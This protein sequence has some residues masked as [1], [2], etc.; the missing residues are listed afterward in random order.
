MW[1]CRDRL[2]DSNVFLATKL[3][4]RAGSTRNMFANPLWID[5]WGSF[6]K[7]NRADACIF[8]AACKLSLQQKWRFPKSVV[9]PNHPFQKDFPWNKPQL[10]NSQPILLCIAQKGSRDP[11]TP[12]TTPFVDDSTSVYSWSSSI[13]TPSFHQLWTY[14]VPY[15]SVHACQYIPNPSTISYP[16]ILWQPRAQHLGPRCMVCGRK[17]ATNLP[18]RDFIRVPEMVNVYMTMV[19]ITV[20]QSTVNCGIPWPCSIANC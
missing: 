5:S 15:V 16:H 12:W 3:H 9:S 14:E 6:R 20:G 18:V 4:Q 17:V 13:W 8:S 11:P 7:K 10:M 1:L 19:D 2:G